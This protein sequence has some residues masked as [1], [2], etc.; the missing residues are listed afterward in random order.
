MH[1]SSKSG[2]RECVACKAHGIRSTSC[3]TNSSSCRFT[4][5]Q[6][7]HKPAH[8][9]CECVCNTKEELLRQAWK[10]VRERAPALVEPEP[11]L[12]HVPELDESSPDQTST[13]AN[14]IQGNED[15]ILE[16]PAMQ[17]RPGPPPAPPEPEER[18]T[19]KVPAFQPRRGPPPELQLC[20][21]WMELP[22]TEAEAGYDPPPE[23]DDL[24]A[25]GAAESNRVR[26]AEDKVENHWTINYGHCYPDLHGNPDSHGTD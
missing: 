12:E 22:L 7:K 24:F 20:N 19:F 1:A 26:R 8:E 15:S 6:C 2:K 4:G 3:R 16:V 25:W 14:V 11:T 23:L 10:T 17:P 9:K 18:S 13:T 21:V 5:C